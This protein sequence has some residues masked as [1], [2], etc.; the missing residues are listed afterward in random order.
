[1]HKLTRITA[2]VLLSLSMASTGMLTAYAD[3]TTPTQ[4]QDVPAVP[5]VP[6]PNTAAQTTSPSGDV[7][8]SDPGTG[9]MAADPAADTV[10]TDPT[11]GTQTADP[12]QT[13][14]AVPVTP[15]NGQ[16]QTSVYPPLSLPRTMRQI[17]AQL[18][19]RRKWVRCSLIS[20][21]VYAG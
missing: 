14:A 5:T 13:D 1:M 4:T 20:A 8:A 18:S 6:D 16:A 19:A 2:A 3:E 10:A 11:A 9:T 7:P 12:T 17:S 15:T 21:P